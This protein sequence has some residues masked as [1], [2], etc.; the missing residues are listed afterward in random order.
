MIEGPIASAVDPAEI[1]RLLARFGEGSPPHGSAGAAVLLVLRAGR[2]DVEA[3]LIERAIR[4]G[5]P[6]SGQIGLP[7]GRVAP[8]DGALVAT[9]IRE[10]REEVG[11]GE[12]DVLAPPRFVRFANASA[13]GLQV[14][15]FA[16]E[17][18]PAGRSPMAASPAEVAHV[19]WLPRGALRVKR[20]VVRDTITGPREVD[21]TVVDTHVLW[22][23]TR[24]VLLDFFEIADDGGG[25]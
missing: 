6:A 19:F 8:D 12:A 5:D 4:D 11:V 3:L 10:C 7:G 18:G 9:A 13:V 2:S 23:F 22:G 14:G 1:P 20:R 25:P 15:V 21:A 17:L 16:A 24:R